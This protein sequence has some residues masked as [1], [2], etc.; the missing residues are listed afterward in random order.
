MKYEFECRECGKVR[1]V[2]GELTKLEEVMIDEQLCY[3]CATDIYTYCDMCEEVVKINETVEIYNCEVDEWQHFCEDCEDNEDV[4]YCVAHDRWELDRNSR[5]IRNYGTICNDEFYWGDY[6]TCPN[7][8]EHWHIDDGYWDDDTEEYY[9]DGCYQDVVEN[10]VIKRY[11]YHTD[12]YEYEKRKTTKDREEKNDMCFGIEL[13]VEDRCSDLTI[14][15][16]ASI[17]QG[18]TDDFIYEHD[19]SLDEGFEIIS[20]PF[21]KDY[22]KE[23][24][25]FTIADMLNVLKV[26]GYGASER[27]GLHFHMTKT[28]WKNTVKMACLMEY[29]QKELRKISKR[30]NGKIDRWCDFYTDLGKSELCRLGV[31]RV[32]FALEN[33]DSRYRALNITNRNTIEVRIFSATTNFEE[34]MAR[35]ELVNNFYKWARENELDEDFYN[36]PTFYELATYDEDRFIGY[37]LQ[38][39]FAELCDKEKATF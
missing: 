27:C 37:Y 16:M 20:F 2:E 39:N 25:Q 11:H 32:E 9:C 26:R 23:E 19:G 10:R 24:L 38:N 3:S 18:R 33:D 30:S 22:M 34:L 1:V 7:C 13:E 21:T 31:N 6:F 35:W 5:Y 14:N 15:D 28:T 4:F 29:Y 17:L 8:D 12:E 36:I